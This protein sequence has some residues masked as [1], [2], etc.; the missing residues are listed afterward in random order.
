MNIYTILCAKRNKLLGLVPR[1][2]MS[3]SLV[4]YGRITKLGNGYLRALL[5]L[6][7]WAVTWSKAG[8]R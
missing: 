5:V 2:Y 6:G 8:E 1:V 7:A 3:G 4:R